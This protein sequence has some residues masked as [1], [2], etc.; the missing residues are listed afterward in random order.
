MNRQT[1]PQAET[2]IQTDPF[3]RA[4]I[5]RVQQGE[6]EVY[7]LLVERYQ[8]RIV[9]VLTQFLNSHSDAEDVA[10]DAFVRAFRAIDKFRGDSSFYTWIYRIAINTAKNYIAARQC[11]PPATDIDMGDHEAIGFDWRL[12]E[13]D[14][15]EDL[16]HGDRLEQEINR[17]INGLQNDLRRALVMCEL[18]GMSYA[19]IATATDVPIGTVRSRIFRA[20]KIVEEHIAP[21]LESRY[22]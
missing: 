20:R 12:Q 7:G 15:P 22:P 17:S 8:N 5:Q 3:E 1:E 14:T 21:L 16:Y 9:M 19:E 10:Q 6:A 13:H 2:A 18:E 11:R 4:M